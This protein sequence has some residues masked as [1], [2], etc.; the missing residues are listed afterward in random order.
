MLIAGLESPTV[1]FLMVTFFFS[2]SVTSEIH[3]VLCLIM[4]PAN[5]RPSNC[6][7]VWTSAK[8]KGRL[9]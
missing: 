8:Q 1:V 3:T 4:V 6:S 7:L 9:K 2:P 5:L